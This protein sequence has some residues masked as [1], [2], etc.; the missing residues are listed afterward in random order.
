MSRQSESHFTTDGQLV[1]QPC[2]SVS[3]SVSQSVLSLD[4]S[5]L[6]KWTDLTFL[7][8]HYQ[9]YMFTVFKILYHASDIT[10]YNE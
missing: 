10:K 3:Q 5:S 2:Q 6:A 7:K 9:L 1:S 4:A 8:R